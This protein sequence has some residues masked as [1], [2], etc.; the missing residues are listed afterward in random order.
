[1]FSAARA[2]RYACAA[3]SA[4]RTAFLS[5]R[6]VGVVV[7]CVAFGGRGLLEASSIR[8]IIYATS[9]YVKLNRFNLLET[10]ATVICRREHIFVAETT[11]ILLLHPGEVNRG[12]C[13]AS[14]PLL[15]EY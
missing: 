10:P 2:S 5:E 7:S 8:T 14:F 9:T 1:M 3:R 13:H 11:I 15:H 6:G 4:E 12:P